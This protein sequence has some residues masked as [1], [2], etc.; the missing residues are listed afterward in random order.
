MPA[1]KRKRSDTT[2]KPALTSK[3]NAKGATTS[4]SSFDKKSFSSNGTKAQSNG[5]YRRTPKKTDA[6]PKKTDADAKKT[7][8]D[9]VA[10]KSMLKRH[11]DVAD[12]PRG[13]A[14]ALTPL[15][16]KEVTNEAI[17]DVLFE[18][19]L[20]EQPSKK[21]KANEK[22]DKEA[23]IRQRQIRKQQKDQRPKAMPKT[24]SIKIEGLTFKKLVPGTLVL[25][26]V[27]QINLYDIALSLPNNL[28]GYI[29]ITNISEQISTK[30]DA[31]EQESDDVS[32]ASDGEE[33][34]ED[35]S[36]KKINEDQIPDLKSLFRVGQWLRAI[37]TERQSGSGDNGKKKHIEL[38]IKPEAVNSFIDTEDLT[39]GISLQA[40]VKSLEDHGV[41]LDV[42]LPE[43]SGFI[44]NKELEYANYRPGQVVEGQTLLLTILN[45]SANGRTVTLSATAFAK[46]L[47]A[48]SVIQNIDSLLPGTLVEFIP[49][50]VSPG[51]LAGQVAGLN[52]ATVDFFHAG[53]YDS[54]S[55]KYKAGQKIKARVISYLPSA[56]EKKLRLSLLS[57]VVSLSDVGTSAT[58]D[59][60]ASKT[61]PLESLP[62]GQVIR[63]SKIKFVEP[64]VGVFLETGIEHVLGFAHISRLSDK[65]VDEISPLYGEY[66]VDTVHAARIVGFSHA[67]GLFQMSLQPNVLEQRY[68]RLEDVKPGDVAEGEVSKIVASGGLLVRLSDGI[69]GHVNELHLSDVKISQPERRFRPG[70]KVKCRVLSVQPD[71]KRIRLTL[72]KSIVNSDLDSV[73]SY[74]QVK[75]GERLVGSII[76][77]VSKGAIV[78]FFGYVTAFLPI[79]EMSE[80]KIQ[81]P[82]EKFTVGQTVN[83][84]VVSVHPE[85]RKM[86]VS[87]KELKK[88]KNEKKSKSDKR[89]RREKQSPAKPTKE[90]QTEGAEGTSKE[91][92]DMKASL[93]EDTRDGLVTDREADDSSME[94]MRF[95]D[96]EEDNVIDSDQDEFSDDE[97]G[98]QVEALNVNGFDWEAKTLDDVHSA[99]ESESEASESNQETTEKR[100]K[101]RKRTALQIDVTGELN[102][103]DP[104]SVSDFERMLLGSP[105]SS[106]LWI[107]YMAFQIQLGEIEKAREIAR[108]ALKTINYREE[109]EKLNIWVALLNLEN[110]FGTKE[111]VEDTFK[112]SCVFMDPEVMKA[113]LK[114]IQKQR[115]GK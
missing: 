38:S 44:S 110:S 9:P 58:N 75:R 37:V 22:N 5:K 1:V 56:D 85:F 49:S 100:K 76:N 48:V 39:K 16:Y 70:M 47:P 72:K 30:L 31:I 62:V 45:K 60:S 65:H 4:R 20:Q 54:S 25:G 36:N 90:A 103:K 108:R 50:Q 3:P 114:V 10:R 89:E 26:Q 15:E 42:G 69:V 106:A 55:D 105:N 59:V 111:T 68:L 91:D 84:R 32:S 8:A 63:D 64:S 107:R 66:K 98:S 12:F 79:T 104:E 41:S 67:D 35:K 40:S 101:R 99:E 46:H 113:K 61:S 33:N 80:A 74:E 2:S 87:C 24:P 97:K 86:R 14:S 57:H 95:N 71:T 34:G 6:D 23:R 109:K 7:D 13:G 18:S 19:S 53:L 94:E 81:D 77:I 88:T 73:T 78:E 27:S 17:R 112:E 21:P 29:P 11:E 28:T 82:K 96:S 93:N 43:I 92:E 115:G 52:V 83:V 102:T 51:G